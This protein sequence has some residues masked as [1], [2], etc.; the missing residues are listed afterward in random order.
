MKT[1]EK[2]EVVKQILI[3]ALIFTLFIAT[4]LFKTY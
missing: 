2:L 3:V 1:E 4:V